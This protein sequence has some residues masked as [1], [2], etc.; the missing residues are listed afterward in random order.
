MAPEAETI[1]RYLPEYSQQ[2][3]WCTH[4]RREMAI[5]VE[6]VIERVRSEHG[7]AVVCCVCHKRISGAVSHGYCPECAAKETEK[8]EFGPRYVVS[9]AVAA[10]LALLLGAGCVGVPVPFPF[11]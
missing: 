8:I 10:M 2:S 11:L 9:F 6:R 5:V 7:L 4:C 1:G 3:A